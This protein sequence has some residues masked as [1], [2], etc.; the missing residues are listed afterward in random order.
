MNPLVLN[1]TLE[2]AQLMLKQLNIKFTSATVNKLKHH[3]YFPSVKAIH[4]TF[5]SIGLENVAVRCTLEELRDEY[6]KP[7][8]AHIKQNG[9]MYLI[10]DDIDDNSV[11]FINSSGATE[12]MSLSEFLTLWSGIAILVDNEKKIREPNYIKNRIKDFWAKYRYYTYL[13]YPILLILFSLLSF[14]LNTFKPSYLV[15]LTIDLLGVVY[16]FAGVSYLLDKDSMLMKKMCSGVGKS[17]N[18]CNKMLGT[19]T[20]KAFGLISWAEIAFLYYT[21]SLTCLLISPSIHSVYINAWSSLLTVLFIPYS[22]YEQGIVKKAWCRYCL[23]AI[24]LITADV[25]A[26]II[27]LYSNGIFS[28]GIGNLNIQLIVSPMVILAYLHFRIAMADNAVT[29][30]AKIRRFLLDKDV[31]KAIVKRGQ[32][33]DTTQIVAFDLSQSPSTL[34]TVDIVMNPTCKP[35]HEIVR[36]ALRMVDA[37]SM[38]RFRVIFYTGSDKKSDAYALANALL[39]SRFTNHPEKT[40]ALLNEILDEQV[41]LDRWNALLG[42]DKSVAIKNDLI[43]QSHNDWC[44]TNV[45]SYTPTIL[46]DGYIMPEEFDLSDLKVILD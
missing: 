25:V 11:F 39:T 2:T 15:F 18:S 40:R 10:V 12:K 20:Q 35:C 43:L 24:A 36:K 38:I 16:S 23:I 34:A 44:Q 29:D 5:N 33:Y 27:F 1:N 30:M 13:L 4:D 46:F 21:I 37:G 26:S 17:G 7:C 19:I 28:P 42:G 9:G 8:I 32:Y 6:P 22:L 41:D 3:P 14:D 31:F 45:I